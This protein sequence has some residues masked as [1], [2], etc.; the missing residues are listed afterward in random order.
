M[1]D[2]DY[3]AAPPAD[4]RCHQCNAAGIKLW[5]GYSL[6]YVELTCVDCTEAEEGRKCRLPDSDQIGFCVPAVPTPDGSTYWGYT[7]V[8]TE[9]VAWWHRLPLRP[10]GGA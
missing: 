8:P 7:E 4:Y 9:G 1:N 10:K 3:S 5:R 2:F 6:G